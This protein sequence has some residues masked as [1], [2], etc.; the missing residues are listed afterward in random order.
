MT[1]PN[2]RFLFL[3]ITD[4]NRIGGPYLKSPQF[5]IHRQMESYWLDEALC[6]LKYP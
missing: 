1:K 4:S 3:G 5:M 2:G 6:L